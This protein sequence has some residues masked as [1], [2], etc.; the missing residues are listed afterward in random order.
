[1]PSRET[2]P[3][4][5]GPDAREFIKFRRG[6]WQNPATIG[7]SKPDLSAPPKNGRIQDV[8]RIPSDKV[9]NARFRSELEAAT[10]C[11]FVFFVHYEALRDG[12]QLLVVFE[13]ATG[14]MTTYQYRLAK[15]DEVYVL[16]QVIHIPAR[17]IKQIPG[18]AIRCGRG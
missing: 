1:M 6:I 12:A 3:S 14:V 11:D 17:C 18:N 13:G 15:G 9:R 16:D 5:V 2:S 7:S 10:L 8:E 4:C